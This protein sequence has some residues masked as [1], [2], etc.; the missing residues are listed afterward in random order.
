LRCALSCSMCANGAGMNRAESPESDG[1][2]SQNNA[3]ARDAQKKKQA[4]AVW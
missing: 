1:G 2:G 3:Q 4:K